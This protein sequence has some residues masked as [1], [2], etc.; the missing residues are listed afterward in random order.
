MIHKDSISTL[1]IIFQSL[2]LDLRCNKEKNSLPIQPIHRVDKV[3]CA[4]KK[5]GRAKTRIIEINDKQRALKN[6]VQF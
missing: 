5:T 3:F 4:P 1:L 6:T 2:E